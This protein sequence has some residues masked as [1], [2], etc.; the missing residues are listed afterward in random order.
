MHYLPLSAV[1]DWKLGSVTRSAFPFTVDVI[2]MFDDTPVTGKLEVSA[3]V[4]PLENDHVPVPITPAPPR[5]C[6]SAAWALSAKTEKAVE[7]GS[8]SSGLNVSANVI[9]MSNSAAI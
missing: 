4:L 7:L 5:S 9:V 1:T 2:S 6:V 8:N 3:I